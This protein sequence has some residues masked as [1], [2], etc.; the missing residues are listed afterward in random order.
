MD[1]S[2]QNTTRK[3]S[4]AQH[5]QARSLLTTLWSL[6]N[7][8]RTITSC[9]IQIW[10][11]SYSRRAHLEASRL[12]KTTNTATKLTLTISISNRA[13]NRQMT[14][15]S[16]PTSRVTRCLLSNLLLRKAQWTTCS[17]KWLSKT[18]MRQPISNIIPILQVGSITQG[19]AQTL[20]KMG[21][22][23]PIRLSMEVTR[24]GRA[25]PTSSRD[26]HIPRTR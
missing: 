7:K 8:Q 9:L 21:R 11:S 13:T 14:T 26:S 16:A 19:S 20:S 23:G 12:L 1:P 3:T 22:R 17:K 4:R 24:Q 6:N 5:L 10:V 15:K 18:R 25:R 2:S